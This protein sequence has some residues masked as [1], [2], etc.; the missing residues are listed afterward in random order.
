MMDDIDNRVRL[1]TVPKE[2]GLKNSARRLD[3][4]DISKLLN[5][6]M[7]PDEFMRLYDDGIF[8]LIGEHYDQLVDDYEDSC[9]DGDF[10]YVAGLIESLDYSSPALSGAVEAAKLYG[11]EMFLYL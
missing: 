5:F 10:E 1:I 7:Y 11:T 9:I 3:D 4:D 6:D 2:R 8:F